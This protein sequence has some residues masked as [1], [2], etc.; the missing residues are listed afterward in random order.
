MITWNWVPDSKQPTSE[1]WC[2]GLQKS[3]TNSPEIPTL[4]TQFLGFRIF[5]SWVA[6]WCISHPCQRQCPRHACQA[7]EEDP[8]LQLL[9]AC[10]HSLARAQDLMDESGLVLSPEDAA[11]TWHH[12]RSFSWYRRLYEFYVYT[13][14]CMHLN[15]LYIYIYECI[16]IYIFIN[17]YIY[18]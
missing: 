16:Y 17:I 13:K 3:W 6:Y 11:A 1:P 14:L 15:S 9:A 10:A 18:K 8:L 5:P 12:T 2:G 4:N 7:S